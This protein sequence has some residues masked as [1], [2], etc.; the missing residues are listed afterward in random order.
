MR[1]FQCRLKETT[2][3]KAPAG[4]KQ[5]LSNTRLQVIAS[6]CR[7]TSS[8]QITAAET[9]QVY[10][11]SIKSRKPINIINALV[12]PTRC[13]TLAL[14]CARTSKKHNQSC[15]MNRVTPRTTRQ[16]I[17]EDYKVIV[18]LLTRASLVTRVYIIG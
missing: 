13:E 8:K 11:I 6:A 7:M 4:W 18:S 10:T 3:K 1:I 5:R 16:P 15:C 12:S 2:N 9:N 17:T 14:I